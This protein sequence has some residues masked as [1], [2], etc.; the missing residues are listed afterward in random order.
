M[1]SVNQQVAAITVSDELYQVV[2]TLISLS[3][4]S[5]ELIC[6]NTVDI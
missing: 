4:L 5:P 6:A 2:S 3:S 1:L